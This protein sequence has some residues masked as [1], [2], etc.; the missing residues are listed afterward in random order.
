MK[1]WNMITKAGAAA[2]VA[3]LVGLPANAMT[4]E[5]FSAMSEDGQQGYIMGLDSGRA[6]AR[7]VAEAETPDSSGEA[8]S[9][10][11][12]NDNDGGR[13]AA[14]DEATGAPDAY[15]Q[16]V[17]DCGASPGMNVTDVFPN[18]KPEAQGS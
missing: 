10:K 2:S 6:E 17:E 1:R 15:V 14:R 4:C 12:G 8:V 9:T 5:E 18:S 7:G 13:E 3:M 11:E 16:V